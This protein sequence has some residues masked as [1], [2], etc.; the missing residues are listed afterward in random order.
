MALTFPYPAT[1]GQ[2]YT[3]DNSAVWQ[4]D[5][6]KWN[7]VT[8]T[9]K[10]LFS[11]AKLSFTIPYS[12]GTTLTAVSWNLENYDVGNYFNS[13]MPTRIT[14]PNTGY[15]FV[16]SNIFTNTVGTGYVI[17]IKVNG[18]TSITQGVMN[19]NQSADFDQVIFFNQGD[20]LEL[21]ASENTGN[22]S[23]IVGTYFEI[24]LSGL[25][26]G[27]GVTG[28]QAFSGVKTILTSTF[29]TT[30]SQTAISWNNTIFNLNANAL[31]LTYWNSMD[32]SRITI[33]TPGYYQISAYV[34]TS[35]VGGI[36]TVALKKNANTTISTSLISV[37][38]TAR[39]EQI[40]SLT[41]DD[42][43]EIYVSDDLGSGSVT[44]DCYLELIRM[45]V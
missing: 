17:E 39:L 1:N 38:E 3:D 21:Y 40:Y 5:G 34:Q 24:A 33:K 26:L 13:M 32:P 9:T 20:Y 31:G 12:L 43:I 2:T 4:Y 8:G 37:N 14:I 36:Y 41:T 23:L 27:T 29:N 25:S 28:F 6:V 15:Y 7:I 18:S 45:G 44:T 30:Y 10:K 42:Y 22:G 11:G 16:N 19:A 35:T